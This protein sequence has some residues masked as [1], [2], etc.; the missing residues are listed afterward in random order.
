MATFEPAE[1]IGRTFLRLL[2]ENVIWK[3]ALEHVALNP[4]YLHGEG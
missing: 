2:L 3:A 1:L 4:R